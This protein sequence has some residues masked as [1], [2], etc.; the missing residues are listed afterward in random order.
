[1][2]KS[3]IN[4]MS[5]IS[6]M[7]RHKSRDVLIVPLKIGIALS[8][9]I[10]PFIAPFRLA[11]SHCWLFGIITGLLLVVFMRDFLPYNGRVQ[12]FPREIGWQLWVILLS[13]PDC[14]KVSRGFEPCLTVLFN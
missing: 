14:S 10:W 9:L 13:L 5:G 1:M 11:C 6:S 7:W 12:T 8:G 3:T 4:E 2:G